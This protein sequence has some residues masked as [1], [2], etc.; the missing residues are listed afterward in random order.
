MN[1][2]VFCGSHLGKN[3]HF[4]EAATTL[5]NLIALRGHRLIY[6]GSNWGYMGLVAQG[7]LQKGGHVTAVIPSLFS[8]D[9]I[10]SIEVSHTLVVKSM[11]ERKHQLALLSDA[12]IALPGG[13]G[14][15]DE[16][17]EMMTNN[18]LHLNG[19]MSEMRHTFGQSDYE[20]MQAPR[21]KPIGLLNSHGFYTPFRQQLQLMTDEG[22]FT[23]THFDALLF[24]EEPEKLI[25]SI[26]NFLER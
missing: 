7:A 16:V 1:I 10:H 5:G 20:R 4:A 2:A 19:G 8:Q 25:D 22:L 17:T 15:L 9:V 18:Q 21:L 12:F 6:G 23:Q 24:E 11:A 26:E 13:A 14:T 3:P